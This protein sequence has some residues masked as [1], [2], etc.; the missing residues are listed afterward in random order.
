MPR[1]RVMKPLPKASLA[2]TDPPISR[3]HDSNLSADRPLRT[4]GDIEFHCR[5]ADVEIHLARRA[6]NIRKIGVGHFAGAVYDAAHDRNLDAFQ[7]RCRRFTSFGLLNSS[8]SRPPLQANGFAEPLR[9]FNVLTDHL[10]LP[11]KASATEY[12][13]RRWCSPRGSRMRRAS[14]AVWCWMRFGRRC[15]CGR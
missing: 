8:F 10:G 6:A 4:L 15:W 14:G 9:R 13:L 3:A 11:I 12:R 7:V 5:F 2:A 1:R